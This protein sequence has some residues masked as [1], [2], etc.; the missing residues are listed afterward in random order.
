V[1]CSCNA[2]AADAVGVMKRVT[3]VWVAEVGA[4]YVSLGWRLPGGST[5]AQLYEVSYWASDEDDSKISLA[6]SV[7][8]NI[9]LRGLLPRIV[10]SLRVRQTKR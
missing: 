8:A 1:L 4:D 5:D 2:T 10:Y 7:Y 3:S 6:H 9:T